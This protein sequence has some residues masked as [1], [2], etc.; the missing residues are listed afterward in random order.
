MSRHSNSSNYPEVPLAQDLVQ[1]SRRVGRAHSCDSPGGEGAAS[2]R[3]DQRPVWCEA[4]TV[5]S[6]KI[7]PG[8]QTA[9]A[10]TPSTLARAQM[11]CAGTAGCSAILAL[12]HSGS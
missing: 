7:E 10:A 8:T 1:H 4:R 3:S 9:T 11:A 12:R 5:A 6:T 2:S